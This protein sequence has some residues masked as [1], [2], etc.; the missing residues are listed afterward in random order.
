MANLVTYLARPDIAHIQMSNGLTSVLISV[1]SLAASALSA[2]DRQ[3]ELAAWF[4]A[5]DQGVFGIGMVGF[6]VSE[7]PWSPDTFAEDR[8]FVLRAIQAAADRKGWERLPHQPHEESVLP[9]LGKLEEMVEALVIEHASGAASSVWPEIKRPSR[10]VLCGVHQAY[11]H[12][13]GC[14]LCNDQ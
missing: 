7:L 3:R 14:V 9:C 13:H 10:W 5:H 12:E 1:L 11:Q 4:A 6:D 8:D 2:S